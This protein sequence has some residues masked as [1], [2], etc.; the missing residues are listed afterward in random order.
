MSTD[1]GRQL[2]INYAG[3]LIAFA[4]LYYDY[5][6]TLINEITFF[7]PPKNRITWPSLLYFITRYFAILGHLPAFIASFVSEYNSKENFC[8]GVH[9]YHFIYIILIQFL[10][11]ILCIL[12]VSALYSHCRAVLTGLVLVMVATFVLLCWS[13]F[14]PH[15]SIKFL[16]VNIPGCN[17][18]YSVA[19][20]R[21]YAVTWSGVLVFDIAIFVLTLNKALRIGWHNPY[22]LWHV[23][24]RDGTVYFVVLFFSNALNITLF[25]LGPALHKGVGALITNALSATLVCRLMLSLRAESDRLGVERARAAAEGQPGMSAFGEEYILGDEDGDGRDFELGELEFTGMAGRSLSFS[26]DGC[27]GR[28]GDRDKDEDG[29]GDIESRGSVRRMKV[30]N[31]KTSGEVES[32]FMDARSGSEFLGLGTGHTAQTSERS[33]ARLLPNLDFEDRHEHGVRVVSLPVLRADDAVGVGHG[34]VVE[35]RR[36]KKSLDV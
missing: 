28:S 24:L 19:D 11:A 21:R 8:H 35:V 9:T 32:S 15:D 22:T 4:I 18:I 14:M 34:G 5:A 31:G 3:T 23:L 16:D 33:S 13:L 1:L 25:L 2:Q 7:W 6:L 36:E 10:T 29:D 30:L 17:P 27:M 12:R 26:V 20:G